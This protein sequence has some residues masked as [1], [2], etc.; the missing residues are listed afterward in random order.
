MHKQFPTLLGKLLSCRKYAGLL[1]GFTWSICRHLCHPNVVQLVGV[2]YYGNTLQSI[3]MELM[4]KVLIVSHY[5]NFITYF[6]RERFP[7]I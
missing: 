6:D 1:H 7:S 4:G 3:V 5:G 2:H